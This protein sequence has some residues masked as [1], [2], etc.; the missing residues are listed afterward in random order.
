MGE[1]LPV[2]SV[3]ERCKSEVV[4]DAGSTP[5]CLINLSAL[6][7]SGNTSV[8]HTEIR[9]STLLGYTTLTAYRLQSM[10]AVGQPGI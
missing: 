5:V 10:G 3:K 8:L 7:A 1:W 9:S 6:S 2:L 4:P